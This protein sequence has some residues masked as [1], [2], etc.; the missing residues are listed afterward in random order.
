MS[1][2]VGEDLL[3]IEFEH[4][5]VPSWFMWVAAGIISGMMFRLGNALC[6]YLERR[7]K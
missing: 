4:I 6:M 2:Y 5:Y 1:Y 3:M 7:A